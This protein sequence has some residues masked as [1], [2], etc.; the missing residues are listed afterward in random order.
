MSDAISMARVIDNIVINIEMHD[1]DT[2]KDPE[3]IEINVNTGEPVIGE[4]YFPE[5]NTF[6]NSMLEKMQDPFFSEEQKQ[7]EK[8]L[9]EFL[10]Q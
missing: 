4:R 10:N 2:E 1:S 3:L 7:F 6:E 9:D 8:D 5:T